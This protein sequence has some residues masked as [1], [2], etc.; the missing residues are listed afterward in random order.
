MFSTRGGKLLYFVVLVLALA[1]FGARAD[2]MGFGFEGTISPPTDDFVV[3]FLFTIYADSPNVLIETLSSDGGIFDPLAAPY[4]SQAVDAGGFQTLLSLFDLAGNLISTSATCGG[5]RPDDACMGGPHTALDPLGAGTYI[6]ALT[7]YGNYPNT[8][9]LSDGF[10]WDGAGNQPGGPFPGPV[11]GNLTGNYALEILNVD[12]ATTTPEPGGFW[13][14]VGGMAAI[15]LGLVRRKRP[16][17][18][19][20]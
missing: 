8:N 17:A 1:P 6:L 3:Q 12:D 16:G 2:T 11:G 19:A 15:A 7:E 13:L 9:L 4:G 5:L 18:T 14:F 10:N 20:G